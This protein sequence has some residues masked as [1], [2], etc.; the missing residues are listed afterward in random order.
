MWSRGLAALV[1]LLIG[2]VTGSSP[3]DARAQVAGVD[4]FLK[5]DSLVMGPGMC[6]RAYLVISNG[7]QR[8]I[9]NIKVRAIAAESLVVALSPSAPRTLRSGGTFAPILAVSG[10]SP[11][12][13]LAAVIRVD[14]T[15]DAGAAPSLPKFAVLRLL[16]NSFESAED[17]VDVTILAPPASLA[18]FQD[19]RMYLQVKNKSN[20]SVIIS[21]VAGQAQFVTA[22]PDTLRHAISPR[23]SVIVELF[24]KTNERVRSGKYPVVVKIDLSWRALC[25]PMLGSLVVSREIEVGVAGESAVL[26]AVAVPSFLLLPGFL[27]V[28]A[29]ALLWNRR[30]FRPSSSADFPLT[31]GEPDFWL[32]AVTL[33]M[34]MAVAYPYLSGRGSYLT[35][36]GS[37]DVLL[38][39]F[40]SIGLGVIGYITFHGARSIWFLRIP[41]TG[42]DALTV[43]EKL[44]HCGSFGLEQEICEFAINATTM[45]GFVAKCR[46]RDEE[47]WFVAPLIRYSLNS[48]EPSD[49]D[50][51]DKALSSADLKQF[52]AVAKKLGGKLDLKWTLQGDW[53]RPIPKRECTAKESASIVESALVA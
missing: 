3:A 50:D 29:F 22:A 35:A 14:Y 15:V 43:L 28:T 10:R 16:P 32:A 38:V 2:A 34:M 51:V 27:M 48:V 46:G 52:V 23:G 49:Q 8:D 1:W 13:S 7:T 53:P 25:R 37:E 44:G 36:Y 40:L 12:A 30:L 11:S 33:S 41:R 24:L 6:G 47:T 42:D 17:A 21:R 19:G 5:P 45:R 9:S 26:T 4:V 31:K 39:W 18:Q 20:D